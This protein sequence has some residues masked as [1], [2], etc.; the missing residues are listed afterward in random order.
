MD[1]KI[2]KPNFLELNGFKFSFYMTNH[3]SSQIPE[4]V[5][6]KAICSKISSYH[7]LTFPNWTRLKRDFRIIRI[8]SRDDLF[9]YLD[10]NSQRKT[11]N[12]LIF[13]RVG[14]NIVVR[15]FG[16]FGI[17]KNEDFEKKVDQTRLSLQKLK[18]AWLEVNSSSRSKKQ[19]EKERNDIIAKVKANYWAAVQLVEKK[20]EDKK[21]ELKEVATRVFPDEESRNDLIRKIEKITVKTGWV[22]VQQVL[23]AVVAEIIAEIALV[24]AKVAAKQSSKQGAKT[25]SKEAAKVTAKGIPFLGLAVGAGFAVWRMAEGDFAG[26]GLEIASGAASCLPGPGT[27]ASL[28]LDAGLIVKDVIHV[29]KEKKKQMEDLKASTE[30]IQRNLDNLFKDY[31]TAKAEYDFVCEVLGDPGYDFEKLEHDIKVLDLYRSGQH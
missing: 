7:M 20:I 9:Q 11:L 30:E 19:K 18:D 16:P 25:A 5:S 13:S 27:A 1:D 12:W 31:E 24:I 8:N 14:N 29:A 6:L 28:A 26:A 3:L 23:K 10:A 2:N 21:R 17:D 22:I 15:H 4:V